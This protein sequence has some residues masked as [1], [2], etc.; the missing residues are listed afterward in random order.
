M[1]A[2][3]V[4]DVRVRVA[5]RSNA[6]CET[7][8]TLSLSSPSTDESLSLMITKYISLEYFFITD[9]YKKPSCRKT[10]YRSV[11]KL[12]IFIS[13]ISLIVHYNHTTDINLAEIKSRT[14]MAK[15]AF[16]KNTNFRQTPL[17]KI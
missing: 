4:A 12:K 7:P 16:S 9:S 14:A 1:V 3:V 11:L 5:D 6:R 13:I 17:A 15:S 8:E 10:A 2:D